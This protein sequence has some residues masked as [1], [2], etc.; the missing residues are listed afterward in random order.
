MT[1]VRK[2]KRQSVLAGLQLE[3]LR[4][5]KTRLPGFRVDRLAIGFL[6]RREIV[7]DAILRLNKLTG[8][9]C[10]LDDGRLLLRLSDQ[11]PA[12]QQS[13]RVNG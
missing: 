2:L 7:I 3:H 11:R 9:L 13:C 6:R 10:K 4:R 1:T 5:V 12:E 8:N